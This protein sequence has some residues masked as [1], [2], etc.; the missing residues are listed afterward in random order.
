VLKGSGT[1]RES[2]TGTAFGHHDTNGNIYQR[3]VPKPSDCYRCGGT[4]NCVLCGD[5]TVR[6]TEQVCRM[7]QK[8]WRCHEG[9]PIEEYLQ[10][11]MYICGHLQMAANPEGYMRVVRGHRCVIQNNPG[12]LR[13]S[14]QVANLPLM[15]SYARCRVCL[16]RKRI[17]AQMQLCQVCLDD[18]VQAELVTDEAMPLSRTCP[19][20][21]TR[22]GNGEQECA[23]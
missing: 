1:W 4:I 13:Q 23:L 14:F 12:L 16:S 8:R 22:V 19:S 11:A 6:R 9:E 18:S 20:G 15:A 10:H 5:D 17:S 7:L 2:S 21:N 3:E